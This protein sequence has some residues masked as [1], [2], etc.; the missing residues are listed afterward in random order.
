MLR[1]LAYS[2][3]S[4]VTR[5]VIPLGWVLHQVGGVVAPF[6]PVYYDVQSLGVGRDAG[7]QCEAVFTVTVYSVNFVCKCSQTEGIQLPC[8][9]L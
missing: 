1:G 4:V 6:A 2:P 5:L 9:V 8:S 3:W 7:R